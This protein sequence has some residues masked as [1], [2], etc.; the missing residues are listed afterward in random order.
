MDLHTFRATVERAPETLEFNDVIGLID[1]LYDF[2]PTAFR[3]GE[4]M[5]EAGQNNGSCRLFAF[6]K[7][8]GLSEAQTLHCFGAYYREHVL[9]HPEGTD[10]Q[11][12]R[13][14]MQT[15]WA[16]IAFAGEPLR[17]K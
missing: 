2:T 15:G 14:F 7:L 4:T 12:I 10:H 13:N 16:G 8:Q 9:P 3:N 1:A 6:A 17:A 11:N 5:N